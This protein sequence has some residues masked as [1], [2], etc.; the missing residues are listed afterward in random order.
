MCEQQKKVE[1]SSIDTF[2]LLLAQFAIIFALVTAVMGLWQRSIAASV[3]F[4]AIALRR[5]EV[6]TNTKIDNYHHHKD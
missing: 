2:N 6:N 1:T 5:I 3:V 4:F